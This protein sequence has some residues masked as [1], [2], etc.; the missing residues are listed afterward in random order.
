MKTYVDKGDIRQL[1]DGLGR[2][3]PEF[4]REIDLSP[5][6]SL[7]AA[8]FFKCVAPLVLVCD[9]WIRE[10]RNGIYPVAEHRN[11][12][13]ANLKTLRVF[14]CCSFRPSCFGNDVQHSN[15]SPDILVEENNDSPCGSASSIETTGA[16]S[17]EIGE[18]NST[19]LEVY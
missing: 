13:A 4:S 12:Q 1:L 16:F 18:F 17:L 14:I 15:S 9:L 8:F 6:R 3:L 2:V 11:F 19:L 10:R 5:R 7:M